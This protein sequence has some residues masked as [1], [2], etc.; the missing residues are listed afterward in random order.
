MLVV[1]LLSLVN[2]LVQFSWVLEKTLK[3][4]QLDGLKEHTSKLTPK[5][6]ITEHLHDASVDLLTDLLLLCNLG[7]R[8]NLGLTSSDG[9]L[10]DLRLRLRLLELDR[11]LSL[12]LLLHLRL[13]L[14]VGT[15]T[16]VLTVE[17]TSELGLTRE[18]LLTHVR[19]HAGRHLE[20]VHVGWEH[21]LTIHATH[22][23]KHTRIVLL[24]L[25][26][27]TTI[28]LLHCM[29]NIKRLAVENVAVDLLDS[30]RGRLSGGEIAETKA[31]ADAIAS[32]HDDAALDHTKFLEEVAEIVISDRV[33]EITDVKIGLRC[34]LVME[35][36]LKLLSSLTL[37][38]LLSTIDIKLHDD[39]ALLLEL[40]LIST[41]LNRADE[42]V[43]LP[44]ECLLIKSL[45]GLDS[46]FVLLKVDETEATALTVGILHHDG[47]SDLTILR[48]HLLEIVSVELLADV[49]H[50]YVG[51]SLVGVVTTKVLGDELLNNKLGT[52]ALELVLVS[53]ACL[54]SLLK[55]LDLLKL[56]ETIAE[57]SAVLLSDDLARGDGTKVGE[58]ILKLDKSHRLVKRLHEQVALIALTLGGITTR[59]HDTA[60]LALQRLSVE[61]IQ[62]LL[63]VLGSLEVNVCI[64][65]GA[66]ILHITANTNRQDGTTF[67][68]S[69]IDIRL[70]NFLTKI[71]NVQRTIGIGSGGN[72]GRGGGSG[73]LL[74]RHVLIL[75]CSC[76]DLR[77]AQ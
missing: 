26:H 6:L 39:E 56:D 66:L 42:S 12:L 59:P 10:S 19:I 13:R 44:L 52:K 45:L 36:T 20:H 73:R 65:E 32:P 15:T 24:E 35:V 14:L 67:L 40:L 58:D 18:H 21:L 23:R 54:E 72:S 68:E 5:V 49:L 71:T 70:T 29:G 25:E 38:L 22:G 28:L 47:R 48:E 27:C 63:G 74:S 16:L 50:V 43:V 57:A 2:L 11:D 77:E 33:C 1:V 4:T 31:P 46:I 41:L 3:L 76:R 62:R 7:G 75:V 37:V 34:R 60:R 61:G 8:S 53:L 51:V 55:V 30:L 64:T 9:L 17:G 69:V